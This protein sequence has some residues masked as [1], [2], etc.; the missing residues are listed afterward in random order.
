MPTAD[1]WIRH[2]CSA[3]LHVVR[4]PHLACQGVEEG[5]EAL[6]VLLQCCPWAAARCPGQ[7]RRPPPSLVA[8]V[9]AG[10]PWAAHCAHLGP[11]VPAWE[12]WANPSAHWR[13]QGVLVAAAVEVQLSSDLEALYPGWNPFQIVQ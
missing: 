3:M 10:G 9:A 5:V 11:L 2:L 8:E 4:P 12:P 7:P 6:V 13:A 1:D